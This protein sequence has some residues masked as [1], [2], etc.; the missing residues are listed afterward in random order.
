MRLAFAIIFVCG[1]FL[2]LPNSA[3]PAKAQGAL[4]TW[5]DPLHVSPHLALSR[6]SNNLALAR[7]N[8]SARLVNWTAGPC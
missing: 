3:T 1:A 8:G 4:S 5:S 2:I 7:A 6:G